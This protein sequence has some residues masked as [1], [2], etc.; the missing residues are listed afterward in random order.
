MCFN[1]R[2]AG[3]AILSVCFTTGF[4]SRSTETQLAVK[5]VEDAPALVFKIDNGTILLLLYSSSVSDVFETF[6]GEERKSLV[7]FHLHIN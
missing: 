2:I 5:E 6:V 1:G 7:K 4:S 3:V